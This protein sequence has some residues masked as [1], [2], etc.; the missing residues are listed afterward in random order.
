M[1]QT[2]S[3]LMV[4]HMNPLVVIFCIVLSWSPAVVGQAC[5]DRDTRSWRAAQCQDTRNPLSYKAI[6]AWLGQMYDVCSSRK[7]MNVTNC[8][9]LALHGACIERKFQS[10]ESMTPILTELGPDDVRRECAA[11]CGQCPRVA[12]AI[13]LHNQRPESICPELSYGACALAVPCCKPQLDG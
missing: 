8:E 13:T 10:S 5:A 12:G 3:W 6:A 1:N 7:V 11:S 9:L 2:T 4:D